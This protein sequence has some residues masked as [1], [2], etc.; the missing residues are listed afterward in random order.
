[1]Q[2]L[3]NRISK[4]T[5]SKP[6]KAKKFKS[7]SSYRTGVVGEPKILGAKLATLPM[8]TI[9]NE[10]IADTK[11]PLAFL[12][13]NRRKGKDLSCGQPRTC[14]PDDRNANFYF[15]PLGTVGQIKD[16]HAQPGCQNWSIGGLAG[17]DYAF[18]QGG[19][20]FLADYERIKGTVNQNW[21]RFALN[22]AHFSFYGTYMP[23]SASR[24]AF[25][26]IVAGGHEWFDIHRNTPGGKAKGNPHGNEFDAL[27][28]LSYNVVGKRDSCGPTKFQF[29]PMAN[30][31][32][33]YL[34][35]RKYHEHQAEMFNF[36]VHS[37]SNKSLRSTLGTW[38]SY[39]WDW[40]NF[41][42]TPELYMAWQREFL[43][44]NHSLYA[45][46]LVVVEP[47]QSLTTVGAGRN[48]FQ[49]G[50]DLMFTLYNQYGIEV[51][52][53]FEWNNLFHDNAFYV[54]FNVEF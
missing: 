2:N 4:P 44:R 35:T 23:K 27:F 43:D 24:L 9:A 3:R 42:F 11:E 16:R 20:G 8:Q 54:G 36:N 17:F 18:E 13:W 22:Q 14:C 31:Q 34:D 12:N 10:V 5:E 37:Q 38:L 52:Y 40:R 39:A 26:A 25:D 33:I 32:Y 48:I 19:I 21:G 49:A 6:K 45:S 7:K 50:L 15:G 41:S 53:D 46:S 51:S 29:T 30:I 1:M 47:T 28:G